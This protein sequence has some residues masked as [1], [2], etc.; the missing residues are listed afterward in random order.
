MCTDYASAPFLCPRKVLF[1]NAKSSWAEKEGNSMNRI[2]NVLWVVLF[3]CISHNLALGSG[4]FQNRI[5]PIKDA[6][7][8]I[9]IMRWGVPSGGVGGLSDAKKDR[10]I[11]QVS[12]FKYTG[13]K[14]I[15]ESLPVNNKKYVMTIS[16]GVHVNRM[17][18]CTICNNGRG[19][20]Y[21]G[22]VNAVG[23]VTGGCYFDFEFPRD[24]ALKKLRLVDVQALDSSESLNY[25]VKFNVSPD[26][27]RS[28][29][30]IPVSAKANMHTPKYTLEQVEVSE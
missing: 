13:V 10:I 21:K 5:V 18:N 4:Y 2:T 15:F 8:N 7:V 16:T 1:S 9:T 27:M 24:I 12:S 17:G 30:A 23:A 19:I 3:A 28:P 11:G 22:G 6:D 14:L 29:G 20:A 25:F 26:L